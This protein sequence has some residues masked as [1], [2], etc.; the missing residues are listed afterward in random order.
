[1]KLLL[2]FSHRAQIAFSNLKKKISNCFQSPIFWRHAVFQLSCYSKRKRDFP[3][4]IYEQ[5]HIYSNLWCVHMSL[6]HSMVITADMLY[7]KRILP[8]R[9]FQVI[10]SEG[11]LGNCSVKGFPIAFF[12]WI[13]GSCTLLFYHLIIPNCILM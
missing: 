2:T 1:M 5:A 9:S 3:A 11:F 13:L 10:P 7:V 12:S 6:R 4:N 8:K